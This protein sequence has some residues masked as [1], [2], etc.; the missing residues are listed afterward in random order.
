MSL[1]EEGPLEGGDLFIG[2][3]VID[4]F[5]H[6]DELCESGGEGS[7]GEG[8]KKELLLSGK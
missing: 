6:R 4:C 3:F 5:Y 8:K 1:Q 7:D 2:K